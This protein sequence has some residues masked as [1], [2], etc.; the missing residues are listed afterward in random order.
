MVR[1]YLL[2]GEVQLYK[3]PDSNKWQCSASVGGKQRRS[4]TNETSLERAR[5]AAKDLY[6]T[7]IGKAYAGILVTENT[8]ADAAN[9]S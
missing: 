8:F 4:S 7:L 6:L 1:F 2:G 9:N 5:E 3:R